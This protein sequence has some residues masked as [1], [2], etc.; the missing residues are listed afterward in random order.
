MLHLIGHSLYK[1][2][3]FL[4]ASGAVQ[5]ARL[6]MMRS[7][8]APSVAS[9]AVAPLV[10]AA[11][12][13][14]LLAMAPLRAWPVW[15]TGVLALAWAP[16]LWWPGTAPREGPGTAVHGLAGISMVA[17]L[18][19]AALIGHALPFGVTESPDHAAGL[20]ALAGMAVLYVCLAM[21]QVR[22]N[23]MATWRRW[24]YAGFYLDE[25]ATRAA[26]R[27]WPTR[28]TPTSTP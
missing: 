10:A 5:Q 7:A 1:A 12:V 6:R 20:V 23:A 8:L 15:W 11:I 28:W 24:S 21:L 4:A 3:A 2:H 27:L 14:A 18:T 22:P 19:A 17:V 13:A 25:I 26:L 9:L 16:L